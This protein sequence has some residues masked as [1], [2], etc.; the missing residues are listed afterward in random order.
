[1]NDLNFTIAVAVNNR[2]ILKNNLLRSLELVGTHHHQMVIREG[3]ASA[4]LAHNSAIDQAVNDVIVFVHQ[5]V[6]FPGRWLAGLAESIRKLEEQG[7]QWGILGSF[8]NRLDLQNGIGRVYTTGRGLHGIAIDAPEPV[9]TL[10]EIVLVIRKS[11][12]LR[13]DV[14]LP[15]YH[16][17]G[18][19]ICLTADSL[20]Y[21]NF[22]VPGFCVH[23]TDEIVRLP[24]EFMSNYHYIKRK[25]ADRLPIKTSCI[26]ISSF[27]REA[28]VT[29]FRALLSRTFRKTKNPIRRV[30]DPRRLLDKPGLSCHY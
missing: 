9:T 26:T 8:G 12:G 14:N 15:H 22:V 28:Y 20:G 4:A 25:W 1:M 13:F 18:T 30:D 27:D 2:D 11:S 7:I 16:L 19:D 23:N 17:Y 21:S 3:Y 10:D 24:D 5:D 6:Y 29:Q